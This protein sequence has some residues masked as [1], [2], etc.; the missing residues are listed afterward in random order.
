MSAVDIRDATVA[1]AE[2]MHEIEVAS[3]SDPWTAEAFRSMLAHPQMHARAA[4]DDGALVGYCIA[5]I[6]ED[7]CE[8]ANIAVSPA[9][10]RAGVGRA[11]LD[12]LIAAM[13][14]R[15][16]GTIW[17]EV[18]DSN[19]AGRALYASRDFVEV[20]RRRQYYR[21]PVEDAVVMRRR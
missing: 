10:R 13:D 4:V 17:L 19:V 8:L 7:E 6:V 18:R 21:A 14:A 3:F 2:A 16:G 20:G 9:M 5:W 11:L 12:D 1:D 15:G